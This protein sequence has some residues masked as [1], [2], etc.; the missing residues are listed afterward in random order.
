MKKLA[1]LILIALLA[2]PTIAIARK[3][4]ILGYTTTTPL[5]EEKITKFAS[6]AYTPTVIICDHAPVEKAA[7]LS[8]VRWWE[9]HG[10]RFYNTQYKHDPL[11]KC[12]APNPEGHILVHLGWPDVFEKPENLAV[13]HFYVDNNTKDIRWAKIYLRMKPQETVL[14]HELGHALGYFHLNK[15]G[16]LMNEKLINGGWNDAGLRKPYNAQRHEKSNHHSP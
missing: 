4:K 7:A 12:T 1:L 2:T 15:P 9:K 6:W 13:T 11:K 16:H 14:E 5:V 8:A 3:P 10:F